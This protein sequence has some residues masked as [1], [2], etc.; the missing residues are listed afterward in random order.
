[1]NVL[2]VSLLCIAVYAVLL[3]LWLRYDDDSDNYSSTKGGRE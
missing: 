3:V 2:I 1:M